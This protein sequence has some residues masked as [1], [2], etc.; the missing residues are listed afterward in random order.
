VSAVAAIFALPR[1]PRAAAT[2]STR[3]AEAEK[4]PGTNLVLTA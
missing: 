3:P 4:A 1:R 2:D